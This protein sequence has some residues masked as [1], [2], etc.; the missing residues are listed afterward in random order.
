[1]DN[2]YY[3]FSPIDRR[4]PLAW[5]QGNRIAFWVMLA[6]EY[7]ELKA[8]PGSH[9]D[10]RF[11]GE[12]GTYDPDYRTWTQREYG[13]RVGIFRVFEVLDRYGIRATVALNSAAARRYPGLVEQCRRRDYEFIGHGSHATR[14]LTSKMSEEEERAVIRDAL[15]TLGRTTGKRPRGWHSQDFGESDRTPRLLAEAGLDFVADW[16]NDDQ[17]YRMRL[18]R[19]FVSLPTQPEWDDVQLLWLRRVAM[20]RYPAIVGEAFDTLYD[21]GGRVFCLALH[22]WLIGMAHRIRYLDEALQR[23]TRKP[24]I[25]QAT[26]SD[27]VDAF[28]ETR[29]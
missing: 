10:P 29:A 26:A 22:P 2:P 24:A 11:V 28:N 12:Y 8:P 9:R 4:P 17:P 16:P 6:I 21:E 23:I 1:M 15:D 13:N 14:M 5:P 3:T 20:P 25:W 27:I 7:W 18:N 19:P